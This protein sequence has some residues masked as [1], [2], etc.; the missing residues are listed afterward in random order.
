MLVEEHAVLQPR[1]I[2]VL[3]ADVVITTRGRRIALEL[4]DN[5]AGMDVIDT[6]EPHPFRNHPERDAVTALPRIG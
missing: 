2:K 5:G 6:C 1:R 3:A 4:P